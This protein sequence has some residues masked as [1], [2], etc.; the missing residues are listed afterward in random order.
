[1]NNFAQNLLM[2]KDVDVLSWMQL[3]NIE[4]SWKNSNLS[5]TMK[6][7]IQLLYYAI[8]IELSQVIKNIMSQIVNVNVEE[9]H[10]DIALQTTSIDDH[11]KMIQILMNVEINVNVEEEKY[12]IALQTTSIHDHEKM[13]QILL[14]VDVDVDFEND[15]RLFTTNALFVDVTTKYVKKWNVDKSFNDIENDWNHDHDF[16]D[17]EM[18]IMIL[19]MIVTFEQKWTI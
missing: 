10:Y 4:K 7:I 2:N 6:N 8:S 12:D 5:L 18:I 17:F 3:Y 11:E 15:N 13:I 16:D 19:T 14:N 1:M 9:K